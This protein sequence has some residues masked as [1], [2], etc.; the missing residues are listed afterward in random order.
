MEFSSP[1]NEFWSAN[2]RITTE[3]DL[4]QFRAHAPVTPALR[5]NGFVMRHHAQEAPRAFLH[6][7]IQQ[8]TG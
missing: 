3:R 8:L 7:L 4:R 6:R 5:G 1:I 2:N